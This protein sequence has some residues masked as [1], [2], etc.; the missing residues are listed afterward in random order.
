M[1][2]WKETASFL[3]GSRGKSLTLEGEDSRSIQ[4]IGSRRQERHFTST[5]FL[6][7]SKFPARIR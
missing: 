7:S 1:S 3:L 4:E 6:V 5:I 2:P